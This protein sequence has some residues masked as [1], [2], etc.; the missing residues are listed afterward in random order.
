MV[1]S[2]TTD[3]AKQPQDYTLGTPFFPTTLFLDNVYFNVSATTQGNRLVQVLLTGNSA[4]VIYPHFNSSVSHQL[5]FGFTNV[6]KYVSPPDTSSSSFPGDFS[7]SG[8]DGSEG[9]GFP[10]KKRHSWIAAMVIVPLALALIGIAAYQY[11][12]RRP[13]FPYFAINYTEA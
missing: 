3:E 6:S 8:S 1:Y 11:L 12:Q 10:S 5:F 7:S 13:T 9:P 4:W 2:L